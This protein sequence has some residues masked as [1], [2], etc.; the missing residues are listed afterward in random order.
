MRT[1][2]V[3]LLSGIPA[4]AIAQSAVPAAPPV[5]LGGSASIIT[6]ASE[7]GF[8]GAGPVVVLPASAQSALQVNFDLHRHHYSGGS[9]TIAIYTVQYRYTMGLDPSRPRVYLT[10]GGAGYWQLSHANATSSF[11][12]TVVVTSTIPSYRTTVPPRSR[13]QWSAPILPVAGA[14]VEIHATPR[15]GFEAN[16]TTCV[17]PRIARLSA[18]FTVALGRMP[19]R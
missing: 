8:V 17:W 7:F 11:T 4:N 12:Q 1:L 19:K 9:E 14:G 3:I 15:V 2:M 18:G 16:V 5:I 6:D 10:V 13:T